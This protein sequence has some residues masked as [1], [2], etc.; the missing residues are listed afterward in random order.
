M[1]NIGAGNLTHFYLCASFFGGSGVPFLYYILFVLT[2][3]F[4]DAGENRNATSLFIRQWSIIA[5]G[6]TG[7]GSIAQSLDIMSQQ[8]EVLCL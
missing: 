1:D 8:N 7:A 4:A 5:L 2:Y 6:I 3:I